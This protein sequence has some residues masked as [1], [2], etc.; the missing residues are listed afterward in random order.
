MFH[1]TVG[2]SL[3]LLGLLCLLSLSCLS[4]QKD[5]L[6]LHDM[7][8]VSALLATV[9]EMAQSLKNIVDRKGW[10]ARSLK[11]QENMGRCRVII[12]GSSAPK[13]AGSPP[14]TGTHAGRCSRTP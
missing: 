2:V 13:K 12:R 8:E 7:N 1:N 10:K 9:F 5:I 11:L 4:C 14:D 3:C 6:D